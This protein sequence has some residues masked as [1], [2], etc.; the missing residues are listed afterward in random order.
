MPT[1]NEAGVR[2]TS[3]YWVE[4]TVDANADPQTPANPAWKLWS[5]T[6]LSSEL[7]PSGEYSES[8]GVGDTVST[9]KHRGP[10]SHELTVNYE[11][12]NFPEDTAGNVTDPFGYG[13][14]RNLDNQLEA[15]ISYLQVVERE[16]LLAENT[17]HYHYFTNLGNVHPGTDPGAVARASRT[18]VYARG[19]R[20]DEPAMSLDPG[21]SAVI[22]VEYP[23]VASKSR[24]YQIDQ[25]DAGKYIHLRSTD[26]TDTGVAVE[27]ETVDATTSEVV[28][29]DGADATTAVASVNTYGSLRVNVPDDYAG[30]IEVYQDDGSGTST[31]PEGAPGVLL[32]FLR[33]K[34]TYDAV[35][36]DE[37]V[38]MLGTGSYQA[39][40]ALPEAIS[41]SGT[42]GTFAGS[43][44]AQKVMGTTITVSNEL[45]DTVVADS[46]ARE[47]NAGGQ[48][49]TAESTVFGEVESTRQFA[50]HIEGTEGELRIPTESGDIVMPRAYV[51]EGGSTEREAGNAV[52]QVDVAFKA[53]APTD[54]SAPLQFAAI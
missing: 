25:P 53:L 35:E 43:N 10:E 42:A 52:M 31:T 48:E 51:S 38:P 21:D 50:N 29:L 44:V 26:S 5:K 22:T 37:G 30:T 16:S 45:E 49:V 7:E 2:R 41:A 3:T 18:E 4:E 11:L 6:L 27:L 24:N 33:G 14:R 17:N 13:A 8:L 9:D 1:N 19:C 34:T 46:I 32:Q 15:T 54:G 36:P 40:S 47:I 23:M 12:C 39:E 20:P 28:N